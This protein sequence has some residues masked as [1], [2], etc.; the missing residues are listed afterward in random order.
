MADRCQICLR[1]VWNGGH[2]ITIR[3]CEHSDGDLCRTL[4]YLRLVIDG[5]A[6]GVAIAYLKECGV[7]S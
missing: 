1:P 7:D 6:R 3:E 4:Y 5:E 2:A